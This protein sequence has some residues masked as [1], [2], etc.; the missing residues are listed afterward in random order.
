LK[1]I[2]AALI[3]IPRSCSSFIKSSTVLPESTSD[4][5]RA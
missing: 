2:A 5:V 4:R 1:V 3:V